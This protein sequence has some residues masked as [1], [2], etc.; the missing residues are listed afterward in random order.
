M[1]AL[2]LALGGF[3]SFVV[4]VIIVLWTLLPFAI[5]GVKGRQ[6]RQIKLLVAI[7]DELKRINLDS[8]IEDRK[9]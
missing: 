8:N 9:E 7:K 6:D 3:W 4:I 5:F 1:N 2:F